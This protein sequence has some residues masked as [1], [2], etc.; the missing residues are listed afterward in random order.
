VDRRDLRCWDERVDS[1]L[2]EDATEDPKGRALGKEEDY[3]YQALRVWKVKTVE[4][5]ELET[6][7]G[8]NP[9]IFVK[10][11]EGCCDRAVAAVSRTW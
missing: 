4:A 8:L 3:R 7:L 11:V 1:E 2:Y 6:V 10:R 9:S 5:V